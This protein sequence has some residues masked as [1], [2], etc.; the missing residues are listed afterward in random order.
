MSDSLL[1]QKPMLPAGRTIVATT[2]FFSI[3]DSVYDATDW[4]SYA[5][6]YRYKQDG[7]GAKPW[8]DVRDEFEKF[9]MLNYYRE[10]LED[11]NEEFRNQME[12]FKDGNIFFEIMQQEVWNKAQ[13]DSAVLHSLYETNKANYKW[14]KSADVVILFCSDQ[15][16]ANTAYDLLKKNPSDW[17]KIAEEYS[18]KIVAD[19]SRYEWGQ[20]PNLNNTVP[21]KGMI[22]TPLVNTNDNTASFAYVTQVYDQPMLRN[23]NDAKGLVINDYQNI[24]EQNWDKALRKKY[25]VV[26]DQ[27]VLASISK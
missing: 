7:T 4:V 6:T 27:K 12:E 19:S 22:T 23:Y 21:Q 5:N 25:P 10:H 11:F 18:E 3:G 14:T 9:A 24:L 15:T 8:P 13:A 2:P 26:I 17:R 20:I 1:D 16:I